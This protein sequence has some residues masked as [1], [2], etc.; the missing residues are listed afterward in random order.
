MT[1]APALA[2]DVGVEATKLIAI[3]KLASAGKAKVVF[4]SKDSSGAI[5]KGTSTAPGSIGAT[6]DFSYDGTGGPTAGQF[7]MPAGA[8]S[9]GAGWL[10]NKETVAKYVNKND[11]DGGVPTGAKVAVIKPGKLL[12]IVGKT[13]G[14]AVNGPIDLIGAGAPTGAVATAF[15]V[16]NDGETT[17]HCSAFFGCAF[18]EVGGGTGRKLVCKG[19]V[20]DSACDG[21][22]GVTCGVFPTCGGSCP[23]GTT[24]TATRIIDSSAV[25]EEETSCRCAAND[26]VCEGGQFAG[27]LGVCPAGEICLYRQSDGVAGCCGECATTECGLDR[28]AGILDCG[29]CRITESCQ[30]GSCCG[31]AGSAGCNSDADCC[32]GLVCVPGTTNRCFEP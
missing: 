29:S 26:T 27:T 12:K 20:A 16:T 1:I 8:V 28:C 22:S 14:D 17:R 3:D 6:F 2:A 31:A 15:T 18:K 25:N 30:L 24:C 21:G 32:I 5:T 7:L 4:V 10:A 11:P 9:G 13:L 23:T 19:G